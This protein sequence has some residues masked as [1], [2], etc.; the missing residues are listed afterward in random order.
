MGAVAHE[1]RGGVEELGAFEQVG[2]LVAEAE[3]AAWASA[4]YSRWR[5]HAS[6]AGLKEAAGE[7]AG[8]DAGWAADGEQEA[9]QGEGEAA[10]EAEVRELVRD[11]RR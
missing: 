3:R 10:V 4:R 5:H 2:E 1:R 9:A 7:A 8:E 11:A 6:Q